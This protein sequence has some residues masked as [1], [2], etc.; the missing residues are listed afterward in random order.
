MQTARGR[1][2]GA[3]P[4]FSGSLLMSW[5][6]R[7]GL[8]CSMPQGSKLQN[9]WAELE[10]RF[11]QQFR[12]ALAILRRGFWPRLCSGQEHAL[13]AR[14]HGSWRRY[15]R[16][17]PSLAQVT[18]RCPHRGYPKTGIGRCGCERIGMSW[19]SRF[20]FPGVRVA[21][22]QARSS[23]CHR[24]SLAANGTAFAKVNPRGDMGRSPRTDQRPVLMPIMICIKLFS[25]LSCHASPESV[26]PFR[27]KE[28]TGAITLIY[29]PW[30]PRQNRSVPR[31]CPAYLGCR[32]AA[33]V[34][35][36]SRFLIRQD[37]NPGRRRSL[38]KRL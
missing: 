16:T 13:A 31:R 10:L 29:G 18:R 11:S 8:V 35:H 21:R 36:G 19:P 33:P 15:S 22:M 25:A 28:K 20:K 27:S 2:A 14:D 37:R 34:T 7:S 5:R 12:G 24:A 17:L 32:A 1:R 38:R 3:M 30:R 23:P 4:A 6:R 9:L 26:Y